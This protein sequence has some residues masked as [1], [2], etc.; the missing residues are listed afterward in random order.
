MKITNHALSQTQPAAHPQPTSAGGKTRSSV[1]SH[2]GDQVSISDMASKLS[3]DPQ[4]LAQLEA[5]YLNGM[6]KI[7]P[8]QVANSMINETMS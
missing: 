4:K 3:A 2:T 8:S 5:S 6:Y 7:S 1:L